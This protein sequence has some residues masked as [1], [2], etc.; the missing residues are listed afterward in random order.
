MIEQTEDIVAIVCKNHLEPDAKALLFWEFFELVMHYSRNILSQREG[1][2]GGL[3]V[4][5]TQVVGVLSAIV[6]LIDA[7]GVALPGEGGD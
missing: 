3:H 6:K 4:I 7:R 1:G 5:I 2:H